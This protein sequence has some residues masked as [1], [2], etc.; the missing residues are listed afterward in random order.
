MIQLRLPLGIGFVRPRVLIRKEDAPC[1]VARALPDGRLPIGFCSDA[2]VRRPR[3][4]RV[5]V[6]SQHG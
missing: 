3:R 2:C 6:A 4:A 1:C 5:P